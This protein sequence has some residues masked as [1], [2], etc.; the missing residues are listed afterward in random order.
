MI[1]RSLL[2]A[3]LGIS[4]GG[5][6][7]SSLSPAP[8]D[9]HSNLLSGKQMPRQSSA[10]SAAKGLTLLYTFKGAPDGA[11][12]YGGV[13]VDS[14]GNIFGTTSYGGVLSSNCPQH[15]CGTVFELKPS[16]SSYT[17]M[18]VHS[19]T[20]ADGYMPD[21]TPFE[22]ASGNLFVTAVYGGQTDAGTAISLSQSGSGYQQTA[23]YSFGNVPDGE[24]PQAGFLQSGETLYTTTVNGGAYGQGA[25]VTLSAQGLKENVAYNFQ[26]LPN[27]GAWPVSNL[28][29]DENGILYGTTRA[30]G[31]YQCKY[32][33]QGC[34]TVYEFNPNQNTESVIWNFR[35]GR[36]GNEPTGGVVG[37]G[38]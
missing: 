10:L 37:N 2:V 38:I 4:L 27:D 26:G 1:S 13:I 12:P 36:Y 23:L 30:G 22:D 11:Y 16:G 35:G 8:G 20:G 14:S 19:F 29:P 18:V 28:S 32:T 15:G 17:E 3:A 25:I 5:C 7:L 9:P 34:G 21:G 33:T 31:A 6:T 24:N